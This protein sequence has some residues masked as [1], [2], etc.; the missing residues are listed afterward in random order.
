MVVPRLMT[1]V[2]YRS[3]FAGRTD[4]QEFPEYSFHRCVN[5]GWRW[6]TAV[7]SPDQL[8]P[9]GVLLGFGWSVDHLLGQLSQFGAGKLFIPIHGPSF[10]LFSSR[11]SPRQKRLTIL[12]RHFCHERFEAN[13]ERFHGQIVLERL[14]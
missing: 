6:I 9:Q 4:S 3:L 11:S 7:E 8:L 14:G 1:Q 5:W 12:W 13:R 10:D 2:R